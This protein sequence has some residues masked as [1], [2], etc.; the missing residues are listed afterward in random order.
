MLLIKDF[1][2]LIKI[3]SYLVLIK[4]IIYLVSNLNILYLLLFNYLWKKLYFE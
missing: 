3:L 2:K 4:N 1:K